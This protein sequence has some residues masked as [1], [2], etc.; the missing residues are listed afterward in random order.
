[1]S[2]YETRRWPGGRFPQSIF[3]AWPEAAAQFGEKNYSVVQDAIGNELVILDDIGAEND[4]WKICADKLCQILTRREQMFSIVTTNVQPAD[5]TEK[6][7]GRIHDR[8]LRNSVV[9]DLTGVP[10]YSTR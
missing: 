7:D 3:V 2:A 6:F 5:W 1:M 10:S 9:V 8:L 4:P